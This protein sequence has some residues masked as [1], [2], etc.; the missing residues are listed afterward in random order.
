MLSL[1]K[2][3]NLTTFWKKESKSIFWFKKPNKILFKKKI[4]YRWKM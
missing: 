2:M 4:F 3:Q 1:S